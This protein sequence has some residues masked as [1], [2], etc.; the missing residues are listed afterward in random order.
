[1]HQNDEVASWCA[2]TY[3]DDTSKSD[4]GKYPATK[5]LISE[6]HHSL[7]PEQEHKICCWGDVYTLYVH[8]FWV[9]LFQ[10]LY[11]DKPPT[12]VHG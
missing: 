7:Q 10:V 4:S 6:A 1:M 5:T 3:W 9:Q 12:P 8:V 2:N 11:V